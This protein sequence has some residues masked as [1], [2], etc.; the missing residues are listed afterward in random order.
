MGPVTRVSRRDMATCHRAPMSNTCLGETRQRVTRRLID[1]APGGDIDRVSGGN[2]GACASGYMTWPGWGLVAMPCSSAGASSFRCSAGA[3]PSRGVAGASMARARADVGLG[4]VTRASRRDTAR[5][6]HGARRVS[7][8]LSEGGQASPR[9]EPG[10]KSFDQ[11]SM[12]RLGSARG[13]HEEFLKPLQ[14]LDF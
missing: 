6:G 2:P 8:L 3:T 11:C 12:L 14:G 7:K 4:P 13:G 1:V 5:G 10:P 9:R